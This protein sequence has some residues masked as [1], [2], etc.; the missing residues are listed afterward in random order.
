MK[1][2]IPIERISVRAAVIGSLLAL[3]AVGVLLVLIGSRAHQQAAYEAHDRSTGRVV[4][5]AARRL[6]GDLRQRGAEVGQQAQREQGFRESLPRLRRGE[7]AGLETLTAALDEQ[8]HQRPHTSG[9]VRLVQVRLY[10]T[11]LLP[12]AQASEGEALPPGLPEAL[13]RAAQGRQGP[14]RLKTLARLWV[15]ADRPYYSVLVPVGGLRLAGYLEV[16]LDP[17]HNLRA[18]E[19]MTSMPVQVRS[20]AGRVLYRSERWRG[21][22]DEGVRVIAW[23]LRLSA[24]E[25][26]PV[27][28]TVEVQ[29]DMGDFLART[30][31]LERLILAEYVGAVVLGV[32]LAVFLLRRYLFLPLAE[33]REAMRRMAEGDMDALRLER[34]ALRELAEL[35]VDATQLGA[36]L[37]ERIVAIQ[38]ASAELGEVAEDIAARSGQA[39]EAADMQVSRIEQVAAATEEMAASA[40]QVAH[41]AR[42][43]AEAA[44]QADHTATEGRAVVE[45]AAEGIRD[46]AAEIEQAAGIIT[47]LTDESARIGSVLEVIHEI[48]AQTNLLALNAAI[49]AARAGEHG[50]G[51]A[52]VADEVR[53]LANRTQESTREIERIIDELQRRAEEARRAMSV[54]REAAGSSVSRASE[55]GQALERIE[56]AVAQIREMNAQIAAAAG[57]QQQVSGEI[58]RNLNAIQESSQEGARLSGETA[59][60]GDRLRELAEGLRR[61]VAGFR[62]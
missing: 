57:E 6:L 44:E 29:A 3:G 8:F 26:G 52:V 11:D 31:G 40:E 20:P 18:I 32:A 37:R 1:G 12:L 27:A 56:Q 35:N 43:A 59:Q 58:S 53:Q 55:T 38:R 39:R 28:M 9:I 34:R 42:S 4:D 36:R 25:G 19:D 17:V 24:E 2:A 22:D 41:H 50:R 45:K 15:H 30:R 16:V 21:T 62:L 13:A 33:L 61:S 49:E 51:F 14:E 60:A 54:S 48:A 46:L 5:V 10:G 23:P 47:R 7:P